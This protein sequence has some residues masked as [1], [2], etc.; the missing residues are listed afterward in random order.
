M[1]NLF[2]NIKLKAASI[3][4]LSVLMPVAHAERKLPVKQLSAGIYVIQAEVA[5]SDADREQ[6]L[7][8]RTKMGIN[9]GMVFDFGARP[10]F[11]CG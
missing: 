1:M 10:A 4:L 5:A 3:V 7:M 9:E 2:P 6:G 8:L 11:V